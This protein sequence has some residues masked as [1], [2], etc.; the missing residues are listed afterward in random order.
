VIFRTIKQRNIY[1]ACTVTSRV[2]GHEFSLVKHGVSEQSASI[3][4]I[5]QACYSKCR[6]FFFEKW[7]RN[8]GFEV[9]T[10]VVMKSSTF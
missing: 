9:L 4:G 7:R 2:I 10:A 8:V 1:F 3:C 6:I 5:N